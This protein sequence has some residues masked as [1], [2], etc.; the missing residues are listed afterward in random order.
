[1][2]RKK[3]IS[4]ALF[5]FNKERQ[6]NCFDFNSYLTGLMINVRLARLIYPD[7]TI[8]L[9]TDQNTYNGFKPLFDGIGGDIYIHPEAPLCKAM[10]GSLH[11]AFMADKYPHVI[12]RD[13]DSPLTYREA[14]CVKFCENRENGL[15]AIADSVSHGSP[16]LGG[17]I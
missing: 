11:P 13:L 2:E 9:N 17:M 7:W 10:L 3:A 4:Y 16:L 1:M 5:G 15:Q 14:Q 8:V 6:L 12:C